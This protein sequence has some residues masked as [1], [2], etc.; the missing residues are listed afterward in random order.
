[1]YEQYAFPA[2]AANGA[3]PSLACEA[4]ENV[5]RTAHRA[6]VIPKEEFIRFRT[7]RHRFGTGLH[8]V[9][10][11]KSK[12]KAGPRGGRV[13]VHALLFDRKQFSPQKAK[14]WMA[15]E[16]YAFRRF[17]AAQPG[18]AAPKIRKK[19]RV[20]NMLPS[21]VVYQYVAAM[22]PVKG[23]KTINDAIKLARQHAP[24]PYARAY[25]D[26]A[27][28]SSLMHGIRGLRAQVLYLINNL[29][30]WKGDLARETK[31]FMNGWLKAQETMKNPKRRTNKNPTLM[32]LSNPRKKSAVKKADLSQEVRLAKKAYKSFHFGDPKKEETRKVPDGWPKVYVVLGVVDSFEVRNGAGKVKKVYGSKKPILACTKDRKDVFIFSKAGKLGI[33]SGVAVRVDYTVPPHSGRNKWSKSWYHPHD[34]GPKVNPHSSGKAV[35]I[36]GPGLSV[37]PR[38]IIG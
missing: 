17:E 33:P 38:G 37:S 1:M 13:Y 29:R 8:V 27:M 35:R 3:G 31:K 24:S 28:Q 22:N 10:G 16:G 6:T 36:S 7:H 20:A 26:A 5:A 30:T 14:R 2:A 34:S 18:E 12:R 19:G 25:A 23:P 9:W 15:A 32:I 11:I 21:G 4:M